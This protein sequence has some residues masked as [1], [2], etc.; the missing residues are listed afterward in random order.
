MKMELSLAAPFEGRVVS[1]TATTGQ[2]VAL[3]AELF[4]VASDADPNEEVSA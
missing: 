2:Q 1:V 4:S 3:G